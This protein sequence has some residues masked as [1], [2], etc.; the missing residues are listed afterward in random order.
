MDQLFHLPVMKY[1]LALLIAIYLAIVVTR[2]SPTISPIPVGGIVPHHLFVADIIQGFFDTLRPHPY[3][4][5]VVLGP[6]HNEQGTD[7]IAKNP[8]WDDQ[9]FTS[10]KPYLDNTF[11]RA[12]QSI[13]LLKKSIT[14]E[15]STTLAQELSELNGKILV[16][17]SIDF[18]H[19]LSAQE[20]F[21]KDQT[22]LSKIV[23]RDYPSILSMDSDYLDSPGSLV[24]LLIYLDLQGKTRMDILAYDNSGLRVNPYD[25]TTSY[26]SIIFY[27][28]TQL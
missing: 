9:S 4:H 11:P 25:L 5:I 7:T 17:A 15:E 24:T 19:Y 1:S 18:S 20:A 2:P 8:P 13:Y 14:V 22:T 21:Q 6:N 23:S 27:A 16:I 26:Y 3:D 28:P 10:L 12:K